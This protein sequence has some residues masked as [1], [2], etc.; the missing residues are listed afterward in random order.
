MKGESKRGIVNSLPEINTAAYFAM[1]RGIM[2]P[3][4]ALLKL[5]KSQKYK[6]TLVLHRGEPKQIQLDIQGPDICISFAL[7]YHTH[8]D[9]VC[10]YI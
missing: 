7:E 2:S 9:D 1:A 6:S 3:G 8:Y 5:K 10:R 4:S